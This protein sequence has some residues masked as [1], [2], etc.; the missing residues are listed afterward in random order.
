[1][2]VNSLCDGLYAHLNAHSCRSPNKPL[3]L[4]EC[5]QLRYCCS[6]CWLQVRRLEVLVH[7]TA[8]RV[9][10]TETVTQHP[11]RDT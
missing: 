5:H 11:E 8:E 7:G 10:K 6:S 1:M 4:D 2:T 3:T 9:Y